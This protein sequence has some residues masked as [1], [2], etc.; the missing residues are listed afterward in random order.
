MCR[1]RGAM[2]SQ[3]AD[4]SFTDMELALAQALAYESG[5]DLPE[6]SDFQKA[7]LMV[8]RWNQRRFELGLPPW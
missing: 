4:D 7:V 6:H 8:Q 2:S 3:H 1:L 5:R